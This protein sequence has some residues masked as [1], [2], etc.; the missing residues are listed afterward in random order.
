MEDFSKGFL[1]LSIHLV[2]SFYWD[3]LHRERERK[4]GMIYT[5]RERHRERHRE[6]VRETQRE[7]ERETETD[8][9]RERPE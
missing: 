9:E 3:N 5:E 1:F 7:R 6:T 8:S 2:T 4:T